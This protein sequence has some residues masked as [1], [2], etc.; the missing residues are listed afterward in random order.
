M[1][2]SSEWFDGFTTGIIVTLASLALGIMVGI[3]R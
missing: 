2:L 3:I 1:M